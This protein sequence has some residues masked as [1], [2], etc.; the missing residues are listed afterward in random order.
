MHTTFERPF[1]PIE[2]TPG[3]TD[4]F[5]LRTLAQQLMTE[6]PFTEHGR[7]GLTLTRDD[8]H[9]TVLTVAKAGK[10]VQEHSPPGPTTIVMLL[11][12]VSLLTNGEGQKIPLS[13][14]MAAAFAPDV[15]HRIEAHT[16]SA[17]LIM[18]GSKH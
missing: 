18:I 15:A 11:G 9:T 5:D 14:G 8:N 10:I 7:N 1:K 2:F 12:S 3:T 16:D 13:D 4:A 6:K 17:F